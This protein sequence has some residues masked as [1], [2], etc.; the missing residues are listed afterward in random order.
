MSTAL[1]NGSG[2]LSISSPDFTLT[3]SE[4]LAQ[5]QT[6]TGTIATNEVWSN[7]L[8]HHITADVTIPN[9]A[10]LTI[11]PGSWVVIAPEVNIV[12]EGNLQVNGTIAEPSVFCSASSSSWGGILVNNGS[13]MFTYCFFNNGGG[14]YTQTFGHSNSQPVI[15]SNSSDVQLNHCFV[16]DCEGK[17]MA[18]DGGNLVFKNGGVSRC[19]SGGEFSNS[20]VT[21]KNTH[22]LEIPDGDGIL[23]DDD[24]DGFY[25]S[26]T[27]PQLHP[28]Q[29][30]SCVFMVGED[31][32]IDHNGS[33]LEVTNCWVQGFANEGIAASNTNSVYVFNSLFKDCEQGIEAGYGSPTIIVD[34]C[35]LVDNEYGLR[36]GDWYNWGCNGNITCTNSIMWNNDDN[37]YNFDVQTNGPVANAIDLTYSIPG[38]VE[39]DLATGNVVGVPQFDSEYQLLAGSPGEGSANDNTNMG[40]LAPTPNGF[41]EASISNFEKLQE[42]NIYNMNG[43]LVDCGK[44]ETDLLMATR[45]LN[46]GMYLIQGLYKE[47]TITH[48]IAVVR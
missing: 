38:D 47:S 32:G 13:A 30:D 46:N 6:H 31:D 14:D 23:E 16:F 40:L 34:H 2:S 1:Q 11:E 24:N 37:V 7:T 45:Q 39:Y 19:D 44:N 5:W 43:Q 9:G 33:I 12:V 18:A 36:F 25:F 21:V 17:A 35:V 41:I 26:G 4:N 29:V 20:K 48:K 28:Y 22:V 27:N 42:F 10:T 15:R 8:I 3:A